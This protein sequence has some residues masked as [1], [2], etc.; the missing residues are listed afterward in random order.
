[1]P[2]ARA[3]ESFIEALGTFGVPYPNSSYDKEVADT[4]PASDPTTGDGASNGEPEPAQVAV[5]EHQTL[6]VAVDDYG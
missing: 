4:S 3:K 2:L 5:A 1:M 6:R